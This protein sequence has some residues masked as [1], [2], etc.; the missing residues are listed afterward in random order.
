MLGV[1]SEA[2]HLLAQITTLGLT[3]SSQK[4][5]LRVVPQNH[6]PTNKKEAITKGK[7]VLAVDHPANR[8]LGVK[9]SSAS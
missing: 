4:K 2:E 7:S 1:I 8:A 6:S 3:F 5:P 9:D